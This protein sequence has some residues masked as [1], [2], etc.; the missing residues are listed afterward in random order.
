[1]GYVKWSH[2]LHVRTIT[3]IAKLLLMVANSSLVSQHQGQNSN[4]SAV[5]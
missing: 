3:V 1:M 2:I 4:S 5:D